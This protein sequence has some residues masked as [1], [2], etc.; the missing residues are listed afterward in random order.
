MPASTRQEDVLP[1]AGYEG[2][3]DQEGRYRLYLGLDR[4]EY[5]EVARDQVQVVPLGGD[6]SPHVLVLVPKDEPVDYVG[7]EPPDEPVG[8]LGG[9]ITA[10]YLAKAAMPKFLSRSCS[11][12]LRVSQPCDSIY[13]C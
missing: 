6:D 7:T 5:I 1:F 10:R 2:T 13:W 9:T 11:C 3:S 4:L 8:F 12:H